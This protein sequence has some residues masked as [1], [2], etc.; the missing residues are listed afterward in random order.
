MD[1][2]LNVSITL[3]SFLTDIVIQ[4][5]IVFFDLLSCQL[6]VKNQSY[7]TEFSVW[8]FVRHLAIISLNR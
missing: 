1:C 2:V 4:L 5:S 6:K 3:N 8:S 7:Y